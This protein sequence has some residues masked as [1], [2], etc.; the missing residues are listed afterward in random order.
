MKRSSSS[1]QRQAWRRLSV[2]PFVR[3]SSR[4]FRVLVR[5][6][7][8]GACVC[9]C[10][11]A[12]A[13]RPR[14]LRCRQKSVRVSAQPRT[15]SKPVGL[16]CELR[17]FIR[18]PVRPSARPTD[19]RASTQQYDSTNSFRASCIRDPHVRV[20]TVLQWF[21]ALFLSATYL[22]LAAIL[23]VCRSPFRLWFPCSVCG[24]LLHVFVF[25]SRCSVSLSSCW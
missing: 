20:A 10:V 25:L 19:R 11:M 21:F 14:R 17:R 6:R 7:L 18:P 8:C 16:R 3:S 4:L 5:R 12:I 1:R 22:S 2:R 15:V 23:S 24:T 13:V 9:A